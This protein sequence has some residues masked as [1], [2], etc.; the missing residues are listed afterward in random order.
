KL[1]SMA[2][3]GVAVEGSMR[4]P[5]AAPCLSGRESAYVNECLQTNWISSQGPFIKQFESR[6]ADRVER[7]RGIATCNGTMA[8]HLA[9]LGLGIGPGDEVIVPS[10]T[11]VASANPI[12]Y[13]GAEPVF[14][15]SDRETWCISAESAAR[16]I[17]AR[18]RGII[19]VHLYGQPCDMRSLVDLAEMH[20]LW[21]LEDCAQSQGANYFGRP[22][23]GFGI[24]ATF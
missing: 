8:L 16:L 4:Y 24:A 11:Y 3:P 18:T 14:A 9:L 22:T 2:F 20:N 15:D 17:T 6:F 23:G 12:T 19:P 21:L 10:L 1:L 5:L 7:E 13:C